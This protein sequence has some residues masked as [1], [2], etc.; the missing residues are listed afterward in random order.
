MKFKFLFALLL[1]FAM[2]FTSCDDDDIM[3]NW[4]EMTYFEG[5]ARANGVSFSLNNKGYFGMGENVNQSGT[6]GGYLTDFWQYDP[7]KRAWKE[8][9]SFPGV[10]RAYSFCTNTDS[11]GYVGGGYDGKVDYDDFWEY[12]PQTNSWTQLEN[13][14][15]GTRRHASAFAIGND[16]YAGLGSQD[17]NQTYMND[18]YKFSNGKWSKISGFGGQKRI[19]ASAFSLNGLGYIVSGL[20][21]SSLND[22]WSYDP[23][24]DSWTQHAKIDEDDDDDD[25][26]LSSAPRYNACN[27]IS[28]GKV[29][30]CFGIASSSL[31]YTVVEWDPASGQWTEKN[32]LESA[33]PREG[34]KAFVIDDKGYIVGGRN[35]SSYYY[36]CYMFEPNEERDTDD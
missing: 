21:N 24:T 32:G 9:A 2:I 10:A 3:G 18:F 34:S 16:V 11:K 19:K 1:G 33:L 36:D 30:F 22:M 26:G 12:D 7:E 17:K 4:I 13:F 25:L 23:T 27:F 5:S 8:V 15:G 14:L 6:T 29:Y 35:S 31:T 20:G 28:E